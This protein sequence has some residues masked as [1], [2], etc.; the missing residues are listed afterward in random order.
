MEIKR[1]KL[2]Q[3]RVCFNVHDDL[4][5]EITFKMSSFNIWKLMLIYALDWLHGK[6][7]TQQD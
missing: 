4:E 2:R 7:E 6:D 5:D 3:Q 1:A